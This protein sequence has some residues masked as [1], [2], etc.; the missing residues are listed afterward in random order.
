MREKDK[1]IDLILDRI[2]TLSQRQYSLTSQL[3]YLSKLAIKLG[4]YDAD[5]Y[6]KVNMFHKGL[7]IK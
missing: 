6:I 7:N 1:E 4:L 3:S 5:D 2:P